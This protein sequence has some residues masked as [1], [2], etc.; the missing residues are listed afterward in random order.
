MDF[1]KLND[2]TKITINEGAMLDCVVH[3]AANEEAA[4]DICNRITPEN[5]KH[6]EFGYDEDEAVGSYNDLKA[7]YP[8]V[9]STLADGRVRVIMHLREKSDLEKRLEALEESQELQNEVL[10][11]LIMEG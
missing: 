6:V 11:T 3:I 1:M 9:R 5:L 8:P 2:G 7:I 10:D 4:V